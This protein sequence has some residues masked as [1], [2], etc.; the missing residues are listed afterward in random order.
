MSVRAKLGLL[1]VVACAGLSCLGGGGL[2]AL[3][4]Q[5]Q[6][7]EQALTTQAAFGR[8]LVGIETAHARFKIQV[9]EWKNIL[10]RGNDPLLFDKYS[11][12]FANEE[13]A[14]Q[15]ALAE[16]GREFVALDIDAA[17]LNSLLAA[18]ATLGKNYRTAL[19]AF[20][21]SDPLS[22][23]KVDRSVKGMDRPASEGMDALVKKIEVLAV[24]KASFAI[25]QSADDY[26]AT[27][28]LFLAAFLAA[29][30]LLATFALL[31]VRAL[32]RQLGGDPVD[33]V[34]AVRRI[35]GGDVSNGHGIL[36]NAREGIMLALSQM[37]MKLQGLIRD[38]YANASTL[39]SSANKLNEGAAKAAATAGHQSA[40]AEEIAAS[41]EELAVSITNAAENAQLAK[42]KAACSGR[43]ASAGAQTVNAAAGAL[44]NIS[45]HVQQTAGQINALGMQS[46]EIGQIAQIIREIAEQTNLLALNAAIEAA[47]AGESGRGF[48]VVA[49]EV[50]KLAERTTQSTTQIAQVIAKIKAGTDDITHSIGD[51]VAQVTAAATC[52]EEAAASV[53]RIE[54]MTQ[55]VVMVV[56]EV[57]QALSEQ[58]VA[59]SNIASHAVVIAQQA[60]GLTRRAGENAAEAQSLMALSEQLHGTVGA[61]RH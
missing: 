1:V 35:A 15:K 13:H 16:A 48:A 41:C 26:R 50:R 42:D 59:A 58:K 51:V 7:L 38:L 44:R 36:D 56:S 33:A 12:A 34:A 30:I 23:Q 25:E 6:K 22:G 5:Q 52:G 55:E 24:D 47:R 4:H 17:P 45:E 49:D 28:N 3:M 27:R 53:T 21:K 46:S 11:K 9:Q 2:L 8:A 37:R 29:V 18:H 32:L 40:T 19:D 20:E 43:Q 10:L 31:I 14:V 60:D 39:Q 61:F 57:T 54:Q